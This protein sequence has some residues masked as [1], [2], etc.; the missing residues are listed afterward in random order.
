MDDRFR[1]SGADRDRA[2]AVLRDH[3]AAGRLTGGELDA[4]LAAALTATT[5]GELRRVLADL[6]EPWLADQQPSRLP[7]D[8]GGLERGYRRLLACYP[9]A[10]RRVHEVEMLAVL[11]TA[12]PDRQRRPGIT[13]AAN[14]I[15]GALRVR[16]QPSRKGTEPGWRDALAVLSVMLPVIVFTTAATQEA[17]L[18]HLYLRLPGNPILRM[19]FLP[20]LAAQFTAPLALSAIALLRVRRGAGLVAVAALIGLAYL[21]GWENLRFEYLTT[22]NPYILLALG[23][24]VVAV[25]ASP[26]PRRG[27][28]LLTW[29]H[30]AFAVIA[31]CA[32]TITSYPL[33]LAVVA[34]VCAAMAL[35]SS[36]GRWLLILLAAATWP[37]VN[38]P[39]TVST[40]GLWQGS[41]FPM[42]AGPLMRMDVALGWI[43]QSYLLP[44]VLLTLFVAAACRDSLRSRRL[45][46]PSR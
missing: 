46:T 12:A 16:C 45:A 29:K 6:P 28:Q 15:W 30:V 40:F 10:Y 21:A 41:I 7:P 5:F 34:L 23:L 36:L 19:H 14:L 32:V 11:M 44:A 42:D 37:Y 24:Q 18:L 22:F 43:G 4:R 17:W 39:L 25:A 9:V 8:R 2:A 3:F 26:G 31:T 27:L 35:A 1:T 20:T 33:S 13:E 38:P